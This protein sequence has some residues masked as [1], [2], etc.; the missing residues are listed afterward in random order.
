MISISVLKFLLTSKDILRLFLVGL[1][2]SPHFDFQK[3]QKQKKDQ[4]IGKVSKTL[5]NDYLVCY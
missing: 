1:R 5:Q 2:Y 3:S 4:M